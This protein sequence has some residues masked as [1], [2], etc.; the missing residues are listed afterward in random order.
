MSDTSTWFSVPGGDGGPKFWLRDADYRA[1][2]YKIPIAVVIGVPDGRILAANPAACRLFAASEVELCSLGRLAFQDPD[3]LRWAVA[4]AERE[5][6]GSVSATLGVRRRD[7]TVIEAEVVS[8]RFLNED[9]VERSFVVL[10]EV[11]T[12]P[13]APYRPVSGGT[14]DALTEAELRVLRLLPTHYT[15]GQVADLLLVT[16]STVKTHVYRVYRKLRVHNRAAAVAKAQA[17]GLL[18]TAWDLSD[19]F[20]EVR[21]ILGEG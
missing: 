12:N 4:V 18:R 10:S 1:L 6:T 7:G 15:L 3:D 9:G 2:F 11:V 20:N 13:E 14:H 16:R 19:R 21:R 17:L 5:L 8:S